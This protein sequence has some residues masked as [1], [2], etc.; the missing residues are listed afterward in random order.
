[1]PLTETRD[2]AG[3]HHRPLWQPRDLVRRRDRKARVR[4]G[5]CTSAREFDVVINDYKERLCDFRD[6]IGESEA[7]NCPAC[8]TVSR[9]DARNEVNIRNVHKRPA[10]PQI[11]AANPCAKGNVARAQKMPPISCRQPKQR[12]SERKSAVYPKSARTPTRAHTCTDTHTHTLKRPGT[13][14]S[15]NEPKPSQYQGCPVPLHEP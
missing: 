7:L 11:V 6:G 14:R 9:A 3:P 13:P 15:Q 10:G 1:M 8:A 4:L 5:N 12:A 2:D